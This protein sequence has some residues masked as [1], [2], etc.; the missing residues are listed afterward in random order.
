M[1]YKVVCC[2]PFSDPLLELTVRPLRP[3]ELSLHNLHS[4]LQSA[5]VIYRGFLFLDLPRL[6][7][8]FGI[9]WLFQGRVIAALKGSVSK[10]RLVRLLTEVRIPFLS[11]N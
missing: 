9:C 6:T 1:E 8:E 3:S 5:S 11:P 7:N 2:C 10:V 4:C